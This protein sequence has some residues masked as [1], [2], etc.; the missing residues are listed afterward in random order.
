MAKDDVLAGADLGA[1]NPMNRKFAIRFPKP[2]LPG[3]GGP[4]GERGR[5]PMSSV[6]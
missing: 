3:G 5:V 1:T 6:G 2:V 4:I